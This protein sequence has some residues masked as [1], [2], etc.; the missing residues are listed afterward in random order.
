[1]IQ[2]DFLHNPDY[3]F[4]LLR[5]NEKNFLIYINHKLEIDFNRKKLFN[6]LKRY[7]D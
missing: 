6:V 7:E 2:I 5:V 4:I 1:M 3:C